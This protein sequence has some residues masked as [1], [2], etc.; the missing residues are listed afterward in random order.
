MRKR[1]VAVVL[2]AAVAA[3]A[4]LPVFAAP[5]K[6]QGT[7][8]PGFTISMK[9]KPTKAGKYVLSVSDK[10][11][12]HNFHLTGPGVDKATD[13]QGTAKETWKL[14]LKPGTYDYVCD[15]HSGS[16]KGSFTVA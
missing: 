13:V 6:L 2:V 10:S 11:N 9:T 5:P 16:M 12:I 14:D 4:A 1:T 15:P 8:G 3:I 7:V